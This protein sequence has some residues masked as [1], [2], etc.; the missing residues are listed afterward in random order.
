MGMM[1]NFFSKEMLVTLG[2]L[3]GVF[4]LATLIA[5]PVVLVRLPEDYF[6]DRRPRAWLQDRHPA[7][8]ATAYVLKNVVGAVFLLAGLAM[9]VL[10]GQGILT[11]LIGISLMDFPG[12]RKLER[13]LIGQ[14]TVLRGI[15]KIRET[16]NQPPLVV[17]ETRH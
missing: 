12:K 10:P 11:I 13:R 9:I 6:D 16:F 14:P 17:P 2:V 15:N 5:I 8:R 7:I 3:S 4:F 1:E